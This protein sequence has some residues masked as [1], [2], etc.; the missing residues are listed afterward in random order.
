[1]QLNYRWHGSQFSS[2]EEMLTPKK[3]IAYAASLLSSL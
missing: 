1:M 3:N 2:L